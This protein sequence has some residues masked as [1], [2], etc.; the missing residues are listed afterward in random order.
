MPNNYI[1]GL[2]FL[3]DTG[4]VLLKDGVLLDAVNEERFNREKLTQKIPEKSVEYLLEKN[5]K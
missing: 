1:L 5:E 2:S 4:A 3:A